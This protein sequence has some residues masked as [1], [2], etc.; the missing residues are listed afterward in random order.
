MVLLLL[1]FL[2]PF[3]FSY[4]LTSCLIE[5][6]EGENQASTILLKGTIAL[7]LTIGLTS[8]FFFLWLLL[9][10]TSRGN[11]ELMEMNFLGV[12]SLVLFMYSRKKKVNKGIFAVRPNIKNSVF[13]KILLPCTLIALITCTI[14]FIFLS[15]NHPFGATDALIT[16]N[17]RA[18]Y[19][20][21]GIHNWREYFTEKLLTS[22]QPDYPLLL[23]SAIARFWTYLEADPQFVPIGVAMIFTFSIVGVIGAIVT[24]LRGTTQGLLATLVLLGTPFLIEH[25]ASQYGDI[26]V[27]FFFVA[28]IAV[29]CLYDFSNTS[30]KGVVILAGILAGCAA[31]TK[32]EGG[33]FLFL[34]L[35]IRCFVVISNKGLK[36]YM[37]EIRCFSLGLLP[38]L[39]ILLA[40]KIYI[41]PTTTLFL[42]QGVE[43]MVS[44]L[45]VQD[46][47]IQVGLALIK[48]SLRFGHPGL[49]LLIL[50]GLLLGHRKFPGPLFPFLTPTYLLLG[51]LAG[52]TFLIITTPFINITYQLAVSLDRLWI[53][54]WPSIIF[55]FFLIINTPEE[56]LKKKRS[57]SLQQESPPRENFH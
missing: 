43:T 28:T 30:T 4:L 21:F 17:L 19:L 51:M 42:S 26:P 1:S 36:A 27:A 45:Q 22:S 12:L 52:Y 11:F 3:A 38:I 49:P 13:N 15:L 44:K 47:Y 20:F 18:R 41:V 2:L 40:F 35:T 14:R 37:Q 24:L 7:G 46:N 55:L 25:G 48:K 8:C 5:T 53:Q 31:W 29:F 23:P 39:I 9:G 33:L 50:Y 54:L 32:N 56:A 34:V 16:W 6:Q 57:P 10:G